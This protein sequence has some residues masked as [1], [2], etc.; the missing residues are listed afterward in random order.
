MC[1]SMKSQCAAL[2]HTVRR[3]G[4]RGHE[5]HLTAVNINMQYGLQAILYE[6]Y[7]A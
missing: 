2:T 6:K 4:G 1:V 5:E 3:V 7:T